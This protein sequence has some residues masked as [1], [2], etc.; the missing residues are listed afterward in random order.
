MDD[1]LDE[2]NDYNPKIKKNVWTIFDDMISHVIKDKKAQ[3]VLQ[4]LFTRSRKLNISLVFI[5]QS[6]YSVL[7]TVRL[8]FTHYLIFKI[9]YRK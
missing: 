8:N 3:N 6:Y 1:I 7:Q 4:D 2:I 9:Y 5:S